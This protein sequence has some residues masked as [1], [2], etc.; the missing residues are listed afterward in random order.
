MVAV[1]AQRTRTA[2]AG[3]PASP[4]FA[5]GALVPLIEATAGAAP[6]G[7]P[8]QERARL[9]E[10]LAAA[11]ADLAG[12][13]AGQDDPE[14][15]AI[16]EFQVALL[17][18]D[19]L[20][21]GAFA[22]IA[23]GAPAITAWADAMAAMAADYQAAEDEYFRARAGDIDDLADLVAGHLRGAPT[24][25]ID[26]PPGAI[27]IARDLSPSR[28]LATDWS[29]GR[30]VALTEGSPT[31][32]V[33]ILARARGVPMAIGFGRIDI[34]AGAVGL[35]DAEAGSLI[36]APTPDD[37]A[38]FAA[39]RDLAAGAAKLEADLER[40]PAVTADGEPVKVLINVGDPK[41]LDTLDSAICDG[42]GLVRSEFLFHGRRGL[43][44]ED[45][46]LAAYRR[47]LEWAG[48]RPVVIRTLD[49]GGDKPVEGLTRAEANPFLGLRGVRLSL[50]RPDVFRVQVRALLRAAVHG[51]LQVMVPMVALPSEMARVRALFD[52]EADALR[53]ADVP[54]A[55]PPVGMMIEVPAAAVTIDR[56]D[57]D[58]A[59]IGSNDL[60]QYMRAASREAG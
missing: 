12:L 13:V 2:Y 8:P 22:A 7:S 10:A 54:H 38:A 14:A 49:A 6:A 20:T 1:E 40:H 45:D 47:L 17:E 32:H 33:A 60:T 42:V 3:R 35:L 19:A 50:A 46:Q 39:R 31:A 55:V 41:D 26:L 34:A 27:L 28:F 23:A 57:T 52:E 9:E 56:F 21:E 29:T 18:D 37:E 16:L 58:F 15:V 4:G 48:P 44:G 36:V 24:G 59:S 25:G 5:S 30:G 11:S 53:R 51:N 43:P